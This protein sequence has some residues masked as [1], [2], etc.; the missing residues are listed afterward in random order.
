[1]MGWSNWGAGGW[2]VM[3]LVMV[4][5]WGGLILLVVWL[6]RGAGRGRPTGRPADPTGHAAEV[7]AERFARGE[8]DEEEF[9]R[10]SELLHG[11]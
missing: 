1:M 10:R 4:V 6:A 2:I 11:R 9:N 5:F 7:L 8:I 3:S